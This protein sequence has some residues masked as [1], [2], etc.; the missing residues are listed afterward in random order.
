MTQ[1]DPESSPGAA[2][3]EESL[4]DLY[5][6]A[7]CG[8]FSARLDGTLVKAN[9]TFLQWTGYTREE[10]VGKMRLQQLLTIGGRIFYETHCAP[11]LAMQGKLNEIALDLVGRNGQQIPVLLNAVM[12]RDAEGNPLLYRSTVLNVSDRRAYERELQIARKKAEQ[13]AKAKADF[14]SAMSHEI[15]TPLNAII[16]VAH[17]LQTTNPSERQQKYIRILRNSSENLLGL[18]NDILDFSRME[19]GKVTLE[20]KSFNLRQLVSSVAYTLNV[21]AEA[22]N[23]PLRLN[24]DET[25][26]PYV[27]GDPMRW[28]PSFGPFYGPRPLRPGT[29]C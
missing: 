6:N 9:T 3:F 21:Q 8:Y 11:L 15:R 16:G 25:L 7:P 29:A 19:A 1:G 22:K 28:T 10:V 5:E 27:V 13:A 14:L 20:Q 23:L 4:E 2:P 26:P 17:L 18:I 12:R 24:L